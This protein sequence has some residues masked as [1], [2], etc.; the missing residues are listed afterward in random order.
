MRF[1]SAILCAALVLGAAGALAQ[2]A[3]ETEMFNL[4]NAERAQRGL[5]Q[6]SWNAGLYASARLNSQRLADRN[7]NCDFHNCTETMSRRFSRFYSS[8]TAIGEVVSS[9]SEEPQ[10]AVNG[11]MTS[12]THRPILLGSYYYDAACASVLEEGGP[13]GSW[14]WHT[15]DF[16]TGGVST[17]PT[18]TPRPTA[19]PSPAPTLSNTVDKLRV[20]ETSKRTIITGYVQVAFGAQLDSDVHVVFESQERVVGPVFLVGQGAR[21]AGGTFTLS[22]AGRPRYRFRIV[23]D[24]VS[25]TLSSIELAG[26]TY[27]VAVP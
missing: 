5:R 20:R 8:W 6:L 22:P 21:A 2:T 9:G 16:G 14:W 18:P 26:N 27:Y 13:F 25:D 24:L 3:N 7:G 15:C 12:S 23:L 1:A 10:S 19:T 11:W 4:V 17:G